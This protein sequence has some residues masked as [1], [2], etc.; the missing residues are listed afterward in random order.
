[1][2]N[3]ITN[4]REKFNPD[5]FIKENIPIPKKTYLLNENAFERKI[6]N[7]DSCKADDETKTKLKD[8]M[9]YIRDN[10]I[11]IDFK[12]F[13]QNLYESVQK[14]EKAIGEKQ[15]ILYIPHPDVTSPYNE[16]SNYWVS[17]IVYH[18]LKRKPS[19]IISILGKE[20]YNDNNYNILLCD[21]AIFSGTQMSDRILVDIKIPG[22]YIKNNEINIDDYKYNF[23]IFIIVPFIT[24]IGKQKIVSLKTDETDEKM[25]INLFYNFEIKKPSVPHIKNQ[26]ASLFYFDHRIPDFMSTYSVLYNRGYEHFDIDSKSCIYNGEEMSLIKQY[27]IDDKKCVNCVPNG[28]EGCPLVPYKNREN[29]E[30]VEMLTPSELLNKFIK[31]EAEKKDLKVLVVCSSEKYTGEII[32]D[33]NI[34]LNKQM[35]N[36]LYNEFKKYGNYEKIDYIF[37]NDI[38]V[39]DKSTHFPDCLQK[40]DIIWFA[41]CNLISNIIKLE[42]TITKM[43]GSL[44]DNGIFLFTESPRYKEKYSEDPSKTLMTSIDT[45]LKHTK[46]CFQIEKH[47]HEKYKKIIDKINER[48]I[49]I[50]DKE[51]NLIYY[52]KILS[53]NKINM[54]YDK[55][56]KIIGI[57]KKQSEQKKK[58]YELKKKININLFEIINECFVRKINYNSPNI[59]IYNLLFYPKS[60]RETNYKSLKK[61]LENLVNQKELSFFLFIY[62]NSED[63]TIYILRHISQLIEDFNKKYYHNVFKN[64]ER[65]YINFL[66]LK[67]ED[68][69]KYTDIIKC[70]EFR[71]DH[72]KDITDSIDKEIQNNINKVNEWKNEI[73]TSLFNEINECFLSKLD[74]VRKIDIFKN[75]YDIDIVRVD[76][77]EIL[78]YSSLE[79]KLNSHNKEEFTRFFLIIKLVDEKDDLSKKLLYYLFN[80]ITRYNRENNKK[81]RLMERKEI[82]NLMFV[83]RNNEIDEKTDDYISPLGKSETDD[84]GALTKNY[85]IVDIRSELLEN[86]LYETFIRGDGFCSLWATM[87]GYI[88]ENNMY[89]VDN[90]G[91]YIDNI[92]KFRDNLISYIRSNKEHLQKISLHDI[93]IHNNVEF[94]SLIQ[95]LKNDDIYMIES[96][97]LIQYVLPEFLNVEIILYKKPVKCEYEQSEYEYI[98]LKYNK[99]ERNKDT[100][101]IYLLNNNYHYSLLISKCIYYEVIDTK[102][103]GKKCK[104]II[105]EYNTELTKI[106][107]NLSVPVLEISECMTK[108]QTIADDKL[109]ELDG[110][111]SNDWYNINKKTMKTNLCKEAIEF[112][113]NMLD[114]TLNKKYILN[115]MDIYYFRRTLQCKERCIHKRL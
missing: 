95:Q 11:H 105:D 106:D 46:T 64:N 40:V 45:L 65:K 19:K 8:I 107:N 53:S 41:G 78:K 68:K 50:E 1:M 51:Q 100:K 70:N 39:K 98:R 104:E 73:S 103:K 52:K 20:Y 63:E 21:D 59:Y 38:N 35:M 56:W 14:F 94:D 93:G 87:L 44:N 77:K 54:N 47:E 86:K 48:F 110:K 67:E 81:E 37:C 101:T 82:S 3:V 89:Y 10:T 49:K 79:K 57:E 5:A 13:M 25:E 2:G 26:R 17:Q 84:L 76:F 83:T 91:K 18:M 115:F 34:Q 71:M 32:N 33:F 22:S 23:N 97:V 66:I 58:A 112:R 99:Y 88:I 108:L 7:I 6:Q 31:K 36:N 113:M 30:F 62:L 80:N 75:F 43:F 55:L 9:N 102:D 60:I 29:K 16:K 15:Y 96:D 12:T 61:Y 90:E 27:S 74:I 85:G 4:E 72:N 92:S 109:I 24:E 114:S 42:D 28:G 69:K 111:N